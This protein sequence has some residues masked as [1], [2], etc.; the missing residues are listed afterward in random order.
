MAPSMLVRCAC[1]EATLAA[2]CALLT[3][4]I[5]MLIRRTMIPISARFSVSVVP[6]DRGL[7]FGLM[8]SFMG[9]APR[10]QTTQLIELFSGMGVSPMRSSSEEH[11]RDAHATDLLLPRP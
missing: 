4:G 5:R 10:A 6:R 8:M 11:G 7:R 9:V 2:R 3:T 1:A